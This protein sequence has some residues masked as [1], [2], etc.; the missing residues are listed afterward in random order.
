MGYSIII[1]AYNEAKLI[2]GTINK[3]YDF[4]SKQKKSFELIVANDGSKDA[5][6]EI[7]K[8]LMKKKKNLRIVSN[9]VNMGRG[10]A[11]ANAFRNAKGDILVYIDAD[12]AIDL[13]L[14]PKLML[15]IET[16]GADIAVGS[17]HLLYSE[18]DYPKLRRIA[19]KGYAFFARVLLGAK[20]R[21]YQCGF[22]AFKKDV[23]LDVLKYVKS[24][25]W[26]WDTETLV[27]AH[28]LGYK[29]SE[30]PAKVVNVYGR[31][32]K[33]HLLRDIKNMGGELIRLFFERFNF[34]R[35]NNHK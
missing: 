17:K 12:L 11:L 27:K 28:W 4:L 10:A 35:E 29:I 18:V 31:E 24:N 26:S 30:L 5:T 15:E 21:D 23:I 7:V 14:F 9:E 16:S 1:P 8:D 20:V 19:S 6:V 34:K 3:L 33:V 2:E 13:S 32:S 22:K 25:K